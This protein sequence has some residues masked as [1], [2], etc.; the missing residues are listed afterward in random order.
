MNELEILYTA[1]ELLGGNQSLFFWQT[2]TRLGDNGVLWISIGLFFSCFSVARRTGCIIGI[3]LFAGFMCCNAT[4]KPL[5]DRLRP[6]ELHPQ[7][8]IFACPSDPSFPSGHTTAS[9]AAAWV[10]AFFHPR[11]G[12]AALTLAILIAWSRL[13]LFVHWPTDVAVG[14][15]IGTLC[16]GLA[17]W[18]GKQIF[19]PL[20]LAE[21]WS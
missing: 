17:I 2:I 18:M 12:N 5:F 16:A 8:L 13:Y 6:C 10:L 7:D 19:K 14:I 4:L 9:F 3:A 11:W 1:R 15:L 20:S 21:R